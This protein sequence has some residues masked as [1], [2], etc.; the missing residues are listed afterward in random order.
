[1]TV[2]RALRALT[3]VWLMGPLGCSD[4]VDGPRGQ[5]V[6]YVDTDA[7]VPEAPGQVAT[8]DEPAPLFDLL[9][10]DLLL[11]GETLPCADCSRD[12]A[13]DQSMFLNR[14]VSVGVLP[15]SHQSGYRLRARLARA[16]AAVAGEPRAEW[17]ID[18]TVA[19]PPVAEQGV[20]E[21]TVLL[22]TDEV[23]HPQGTAAEPGQPAPGPPGPSMVGT[24]SGADRI[25][26]AGEPPAGRAC[27]P[28]GAYWMG[29]P[30]V[31]TVAG[32]A[33]QQRLVVVSP[34]FLDQTEVT[35]GAM[36]SWQPTPTAGI[37]AWSGSLS[38]EAVADYCT[39]DAT[40]AR[41][42]LPM[43]C[44][45]RPLAQ[46]YCEDHGGTLPTEAQLELVA[47]GLESRFYLWGTEPPSCED[48]V[49]GRAGGAISPNEA[50][51]SRNM[52]RSTAKS[53][54][55]PEQGSASPGCS[56][57]NRSRSN[58]GGTSSA[59]ATSPAG[60]GTGASVSA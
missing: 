59:A 5:L 60:N 4:D 31:I 16:A 34:F 37:T 52:P 29:N 12:F 13:V 1:M 6:V 22:F 46:A 30:A 15:K 55:H 24:W 19:L 40:G 8:A 23:A 10:V 33:D 43:N 3:I 54:R 56:T 57:S 14:E 48:A 58:S 41:D 50:R 35:V 32:S 18:V 11:P 17:T 25:P 47:G 45:T 53:R 28:G 49:H 20:D 42:D 44:I 39:Y 36:R 9:R 27:V 51:R 7:P 26:C 2:L 38:G 21:V